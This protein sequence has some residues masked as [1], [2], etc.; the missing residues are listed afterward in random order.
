MADQKLEEQPIVKS[1][2]EHELSDLTQQQKDLVSLI[3]LKQKGY[4]SM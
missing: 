2:L 1:L 3:C 4:D